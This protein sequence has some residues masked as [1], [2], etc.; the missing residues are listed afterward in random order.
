VFSSRNGLFLG[1]SYMAELHPIPCKVKFMFK[2]TKKNLKA[3]AICVLIAT[4]LS[5]I[6]L[7]TAKATNSGDVVGNWP[8]NSIKTA[9]NSTA[10]STD[11]N[12]GIA[13]GYPGTPVVVPGK[14]G[15][16]F[17]FNGDNFVYVPIKF[18]VGFPPMHDQTVYMPVSPNLDIQKYISVDAWVNVPGYKDATYNNIVVKANHPDQAAA[19][20]NTVRVLG[21]AVRAGPTNDTGVVQGALSGYLLT[22][23]GGANEI[24]TTQPLP[25]SQ[26]LHVEFT[27]T[28]TGMHLYV[29]GVEQAVNVIRGVA[30]PQGN[31]E[32]G[33][34]YYF[35]HDGL[36]TI[37]D[38][39]ITDLGTV[40]EDSFDIGTNLLVAIIAVALIF[41]V[42]WLLRRA[43]QL[44]LIRPKIP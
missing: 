34:E 6:F 14:F 33:T 5:P 39:T 8:L 28:P 23:S 44:W 10:D 1:E 30:N 29:N 42:A 35:G 19:W 40:Y 9:D 32:T 31:I 36:A 38:V 15:N 37:D 41:A 43:I 16:A 25:L 22:D 11:V 12:N 27:R 20:Q 21:L 3:M 7:T 26:W 18:V 13:G 24:V 4:M 17:Q 2:G